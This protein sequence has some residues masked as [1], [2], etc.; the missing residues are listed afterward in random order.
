MNVSGQT[1][2]DPFQPARLGR[3]TLRNRIIKAATFEGMARKGLVTDRLIDYHVAVAAGGVGM[4]TVAY[5]AVSPEG[6][7]ARPARSCCGRTRWTACAVWWPLCTPRAPQCRP[8]SATPAPSPPE[9]GTP[10]CHHRACSVR[11]PCDSRERCRSR[12]WRKSS[13]TSS[14]RPVWPSMPGSM[15]SNCTWATATS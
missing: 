8:R 4:T 1:A 2:L 3:L 5:L 15:R 14:L 13:T 7:G 10:A 9:P 6:R 12:T 11:W